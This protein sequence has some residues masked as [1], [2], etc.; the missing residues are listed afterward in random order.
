MTYVACANVYIGANVLLALALVLVAAIES[1]SG[2]LRHPVAYRH[3]LAMGHTMVI[4]ALLLPFATPLLG[5]EDVLPRTAQV[6]SAGTM[7]GGAAEAPE[8]QRIAI[9]F[10]PRGASISL[11]AATNAAAGLVLIGLLVSLLRI[12]LDI[13][14]TRRI[15]AQASS[16]RRHGRLSVLASERIQVP[17]SFWWPGRYFVVV[18][19]ALV[20]H[21]EDLKMA[22]RHEAQH[23][24]QHDTKWLYLYQLLRAVFFWNPAVHR[25]ERRLRSLQEFACDE[26]LS[27]RKTIIG[28]DYCRSLLRVA[29]AA[30]PPRRA[31][32]RASMVDGAGA[33]LLKRRVEAVLARPTD[34]QRTP[35][36]VAAGMAAVALL[37]ATAL[38][39]SA[40]IQDRRISADEGARM[41][42]AARAT[43]GVPIAVNDRV[44]RELNLLLATP[45]GRAYV[46]GSLDRMRSYEPTLSAELARHGLPAEL[47]AVPLVESGYRNLAPNPNPPHGAG[48]WQF[49]EPTAER[50]GLTVDESRD[51]RL[52]VPAATRAAARF[53]ADLHRRFGDW[54]LA[55]LAYNAG[56]A[57]VEEGIRATGSR[58]VWRLI[59][60]GHENDR[61]YLA[62]VMAAVIVME[63]PS[64]LE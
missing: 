42:A 34:H 58:D 29:E 64:V 16:I 44:L 8:N 32:V 55:I 6:W 38:G 23:H 57:R 63:N 11:T 56:A 28:A 62:R 51:D 36:V 19:S 54:G 27:A 48:L 14:V 35:A 22:I 10:A 20:L 33:L 2:S 15:I 37:A 59:D 40:T 39:C 24:R 12:G 5:N 9:S 50:F 13:R 17:F 53:F 60:Q 4:A 45:D 7:S 61:D 26:A 49:I 1:V 30:V 52:D 46:Q 41:A 21:A 47:L 43:S 31:L 18:P 25:L 3:R